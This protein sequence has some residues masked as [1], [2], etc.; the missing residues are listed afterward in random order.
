MQGAE[1]RLAKEGKTYYGK[2]GNDGKI[3]WHNDDKYEQP[4]TEQEHIAEGSYTLTEIKAPENCALSG[5][6]WAL[7]VN[8]DGG[9][10][11]ITSSAGAISTNEAGDVMQFY[12]DNAILYELPSAGGPGIYWHMIGGMLFMMAAALIVYK[13]R[14]L[15]R[16]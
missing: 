14:C 2:S 3:I 8:A 13:T 5:E 11:S 7:V 15:R 6:T 16:L 10:K 1:F 4:L 9:L 12:Y